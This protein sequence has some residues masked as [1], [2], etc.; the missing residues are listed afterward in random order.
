V[1]LLTC[2]DCGHQVSSAAPACPQ[3]GRPLTSAPPA[4]AAPAT[5]APGAEEVV[6][7]G[8]PSFKAML[9]EII[10]TSLYAIG[11]PIVALL[12]FDPLLSLVA[13]LG[14][15]AAELV[16]D[17][18]PTIKLVLMVLLGVVV[19]LRVAKLGWHIAV[20][21]SHRY[22]V[23]NQRI[24][25]ESGA[26]SKRIDEVDMRTVEDIEFQQRFLQRLLGIGEIVVVAADKKMGRFRLL[27]VEN[28]RDIRELIRN[29]AFQATQGQLFTRST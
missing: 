17:E 12:A 6:W 29:N 8:V 2:P 25:I 13:G 3:C 23:S 26:L 19:G 9:V 24:V 27:G 10:I 7:E 1:A 21:R 11:L 18:R 15:P 14:G 20:L 28:P 4:I 22:R 16:R 5:R